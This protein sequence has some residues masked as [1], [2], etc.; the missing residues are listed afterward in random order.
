MHRDSVFLRLGSTAAGDPVGMVD[1][2]ES[3]TYRVLHISAMDPKNAYLPVGDVDDM[4][5]LDTCCPFHSAVSTPQPFNE[6]H[7]PPG[8]LRPP[9]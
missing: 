8:D 9:T 2:G 3:L 6:Q 1:L 7:S 4:L 5:T